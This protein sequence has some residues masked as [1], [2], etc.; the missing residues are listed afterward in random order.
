MLLIQNE[1]QSSAAIKRLN[2]ASCCLWSRGAQSHIL[3]PTDRRLSDAA[4][5]TM[6]TRA[7][8]LCWPCLKL[9]PFCPDPFHLWRHT[10]PS[11]E[12]LW[13]GEVGGRCAHN[14]CPVFQP[15]QTPTLQLLER[16]FS[17]KARHTH[18][19]AERVRG[20]HT[21]T[22]W[23]CSAE[24]EESSS[25]TR[26]QENM[27]LL[28]IIVFFLSSFSSHVLWKSKDAM[29]SSPRDTFPASPHSLGCLVSHMTGGECGRQTAWWWAGARWLLPAASTQTL[30]ESAGLHQ[31]ASTFHNRWQR[32]ST[33]SVADGCA[34]GLSTP[35]TLIV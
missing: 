4:G 33:L 5:D 29:T 12:T 23:P 7:A 32:D 26:R 22:I 11:G 17:T 34:S 13:R 1:V 25:H 2:K 18:T 35:N 10:F 27:L 21:I 8:L 24:E 19:P 20:R 30:K 3:C 6:E 15:P 9:H 16:P 28:Y 31:S 14:I